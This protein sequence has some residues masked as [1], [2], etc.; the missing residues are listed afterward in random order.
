MNYLACN[1]LG[2]TVVETGV[3]LCKTAFLPL[4]Q[5]IAPL[6]S[7]S[8]LTSPSQRNQGRE[9]TQT[10]SFSGDIHPAVSSQPLDLEIG[11]RSI[12][13]T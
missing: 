6:F 4:I 13:Y 1:E 12:K 5:K 11:F 2:H 9:E 8:S 3:A 7:K 10:E